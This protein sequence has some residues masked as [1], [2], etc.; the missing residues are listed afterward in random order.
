MN[1]PARWHRLEEVFHAVVDMPAGAARDRRLLDLCGHDAALAAEVGA[2]IAEDARLG[3]SAPAAD[4]RVGLRLSH[5]ALVAQFQAEQQVLAAIEHPA[6]TRLLD[7]GVTAFGEPYLV[8]EFV[9][10]EAIDRYCD[11]RQLDLAGRLRLFAQVCEGVAF[12]HRSLVLHRDLKPSNSPVATDGHAKV[13]DFG[14][15]TRL[16]PE[17]LATLSQA[18]LT[19]AYASPEQL[20]GQ[21]VGT[22]SDQFSL[23][24]VLYELLTGVAAKRR[25]TRS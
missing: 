17:R 24:L 4:P 12:A 20:T 5:P 16:Q 14:T 22:A 11:A 6:L 9:E 10:G 23:G 7:G 15:A 3:D 18:P 1:D 19:P 8:M 2:L 13:V 25:R 21:P